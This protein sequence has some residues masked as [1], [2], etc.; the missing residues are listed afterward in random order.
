[1]QP[2]VAQAI[3]A[4]ALRLTPWPEAV[5]QLEQHKAMPSGFCPGAPVVE[6]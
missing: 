6:V 2:K 5:Y 1:M 3:L 4:H